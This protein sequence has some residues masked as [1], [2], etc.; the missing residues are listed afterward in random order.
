MQTIFFMVLLMTA[1]M[2]LWRMAAE[3][4]RRVRRLA[5]N[6]PAINQA[7]NKAGRRFP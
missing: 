6:K 2:L 1:A 7:G 4:G 5:I 3:A